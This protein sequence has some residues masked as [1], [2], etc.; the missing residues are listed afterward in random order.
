MRVQVPTFVL[1]IL[2]FFSKTNCKKFNIEFNRVAK[3]SNSQIKLIANY[4]LII[5]SILFM[6]WC[7]LPKLNIDC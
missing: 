2:T 6:Y 3:R 1:Y 5:Y 4:L 7:F